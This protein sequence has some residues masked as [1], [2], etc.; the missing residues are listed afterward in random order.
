MARN[1]FPLAASAWDGHRGRAFHAQLR[2]ANNC[3]A[4]TSTSTS[5]A[6]SS[7]SKARVSGSAR[8]VVIGH[9]NGRWARPT[10]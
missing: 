4:P 7:I 10:L 6:P 1:H 5:L 3:L 9:T 8:S 2:P